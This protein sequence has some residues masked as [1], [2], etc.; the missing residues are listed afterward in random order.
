MFVQLCCAEIAR[1]WIA[2]ILFCVTCFGYIQV[3]SPLSSLQTSLSLLLFFLLCKDS[4]IVVAVIQD[5]RVVHLLPALEAEE[6]EVLNCLSL[7]S[8]L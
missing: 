1:N 2:K 3:F 6:Q 8:A 4:L 7:E 5:R